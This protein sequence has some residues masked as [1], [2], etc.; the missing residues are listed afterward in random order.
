MDTTKT[1]FH[2][3]RSRKGGSNY[4]LN[5]TKS[6]GRLDTAPSSPAPPA[7]VITHASAC[8]Q[9]FTVAAARPA[10]TA[11]YAYSCYTQYD[12][13][14]AIKIRV[15]PNKNAARAGPGHRTSPRRASHS[16]EKKLQTVSW[17]AQW[18][19]YFENLYLIKATKLKSNLVTVTNL[20]RRAT[21]ALNLGGEGKAGRGEEVAL[22]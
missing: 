2:A 7:P 21:G 3:E 5:I 16:E 9:G 1:A 18:A 15:G 20:E 8:G 22:I 6:T 17:C 13:R 4:P 12:G 19:G 11:L 14:A 10:I